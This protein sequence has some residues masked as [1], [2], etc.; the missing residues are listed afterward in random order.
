M[1]PDPNKRI[2]QVLWSDAIYVRDWMQ[3][4]TM[5]SEKMMRYALLAHHLLSSFDLA[6]LLLMEAD[7]RCN[8]NRAELYL[9]DL[10]AYPIVDH[11]SGL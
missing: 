10:N 9:A 6:H 7:Q 3:L 2:R 8:G 1:F 4:E 11:L 5:D